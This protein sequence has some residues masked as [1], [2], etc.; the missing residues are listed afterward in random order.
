M[1][2]FVVEDWTHDLLPLKQ[3][4]YNDTNEGVYI[5]WN[6]NVIDDHYVICK[7]LRVSLWMANDYIESSLYLQPTKHKAISI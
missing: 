5:E 3:V 4:S 7:V 6:M 1:L 2:K